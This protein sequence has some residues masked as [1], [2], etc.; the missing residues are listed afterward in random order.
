[1]KRILFLILFLSV[2]LLSAQQLIHRSIFDVC[3][4][5][6]KQQPLWLEY[7]VECNKRGYSRKGLDFQQ[8]KFFID[9]QIKGPYKKWLHKHSFVPYRKGTLIIDDITYNIPKKKFIPF[10]LM[11]F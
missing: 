3:Y 2:Q 7:E 8:D 10:V 11:A 9:N 4:S 5:E 6:S 1:M